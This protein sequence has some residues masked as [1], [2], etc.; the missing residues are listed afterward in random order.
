MPISDAPSLLTL[1]WSPLTVVTSAHEGQRGGQIVVGA[2]AASIVPAQPRV[3]VQ[4]QK[5]NHTNSLIEASGKMAV[6]VISREQ[7]AW[8]KHWGFRSQ[9]EVDKFEG[10]DWLEHDDGLPILGGVLGWMTC[11]VVNYMDGGDMA[12]WLADVTDA[13]RN[14]RAQPLRWHEVQQVL[15]PDWAEEYGRK[16]SHDVPDSG[17]RMSELSEQPGWRRTGEPSP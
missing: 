4:I 17:R 1:M 5:R 12:I 11:R 15:P 3:L 9:T 14:T 13:D 6:H 2:F 7:W 10:L 8:V 16:L